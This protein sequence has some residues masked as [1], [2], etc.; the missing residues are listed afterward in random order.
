MSSINTGML[1]YRFKNGL[2]QIRLNLVNFCQIPNNPDIIQYLL[3]WNAAVT[4]F[5]YF[6]TGSK[7]KT[8]LTFSVQTSRN[9]LLL[10]FISVSSVITRYIFI[11]K[12]RTKNPTHFMYLFHRKIVRVKFMML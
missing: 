11:C 12:N 1:I 5:T 3:V 2:N 10:D 4:F 7:L 8:K 6:L 9:S